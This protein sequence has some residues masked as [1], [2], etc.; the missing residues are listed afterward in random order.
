MGYGAP[1]NEVQ[2]SVSGLYLDSKYYQ[3]YPPGMKMTDGIPEEVMAVIDP[4]VSM[5]PNTVHLHFDGSL[6]NASFLLF[7][8]EPVPS[9]KPS[10]PSLFWCPLLFPVDHFLL[11]QWLCH[12]HLP[13]GQI[14]QDPGKLNH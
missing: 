1:A 8:V 10:D 2:G 11:W 6:L 7:L 14:P 12:L 3:A 5:K 9:S 4:H 13:K